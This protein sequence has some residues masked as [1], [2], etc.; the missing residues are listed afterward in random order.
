MA[1]ARESSPDSLTKRGSLGLD[2]CQGCTRGSRQGAEDDRPLYLERCL[3]CAV[4]RISRF[5][6]LQVMDRLGPGGQAG[7][8]AR[9]CARGKCSWSRAEFRLTGDR[10][11]A[12][13][14]RRR[15]AIRNCWP[16]LG[17][18]NLRAK[19]IRSHEG[20]FG[21]ESKALSWLFFFCRRMG[22]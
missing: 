16:H 5:E 10:P 15:T 8:S 21:L 3:G 6:R 13:Q 9:G 19:T 2:W 14:H 18:R 22:I 17:D 20:C 1:S 7:F 4:V 11:F 12:T